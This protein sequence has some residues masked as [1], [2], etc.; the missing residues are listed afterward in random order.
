MHHLSPIRSHTLT[1]IRLLMYFVVA[2]CQ[3]RFAYFF[4]IEFFCFRRSHSKTFFAHST[5][6]AISPILCV[7][8]DLKFSKR[9]KK[10]AENRTILCKWKKNVSENAAYENG[11]PPRLHTGQYL[12]GKKNMARHQRSVKRS[13]KK[14]PIHVNA[15]TVR[16]N[17]R[18]TGFEKENALIHSCAHTLYSVHKYGR[19]CSRLLESLVYSPV[20]TAVGRTKERDICWILSPPFYWVCKRSCVFSSC[21][22][23]NR[24]HRRSDTQWTKKKLE[25][26]ENRCKHTGH[27]VKI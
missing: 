13:Y 8:G 9:A 11:V 4:R 27:L 3:I 26:K 5:F 24:T 1:C 7:L 10:E 20:A 17:T 12:H 21:L 15:Y 16:I 22:E 23:V 2:W 6:D 19:I 14:I 18:R 25:T